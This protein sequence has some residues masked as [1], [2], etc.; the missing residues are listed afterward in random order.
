VAYDLPIT[1]TV[2][3]VIDAEITSFDIGTVEVPAITAP[4]GN[5]LISSPSN[6]TCGYSY[7]NAPAPTWATVSG[8]PGTTVIASGLAIDDQQY[9]NIALPAGFEFEFNGAN[10]N[11]IGINANGFIWFGQYA[12]P[13]GNVYNPISTTLPYEGVVSALGADL[14]A[15]ND[16]TNT[17]QIL[18][19]VTGT[20]PNRIVTV[21]WRAFKPWNNSGGFCTFFAFPD[22]NRYDFQIKLY[23]NG[24]ANSNVID[25]IHRDQNPVCIDGNGLSAQVGIRGLTNT[26]FRNRARTGNTDNTNTVAGGTNTAAI[27]HGG[28]NYFTSNTRMRYSPTITFPTVTPSPVAGNVCPALDVTLTAVST[29]PTLQ[30]FADNSAIPSATAL[31][32]AAASTG[33]YVIR[34]SSGACSRASTPP[35]DVTILPCFPI[36]LGGTIG[37]ETDWNTPTNWSSNAVPTL[38]DSAVVPLQPFLPIVGTT[39]DALAKFVTLETDATLEII[40]GRSLTF[41]ATGGIINNAGNTVDLGSGLVIFNGSGQVS[42]SNVLEFG[43]VT[44]NAITTLNTVPVINGALTMNSGSS[45]TASPDYSGTSTLVYNQSGVVNP[46]NE[47]TGNSNVAGTGIPQ[48]VSIQNSTTLELPLTDR[49]IAGNLSIIDGSL[50]MNA[51]SGDLYIGGDWIRNSTDGLFTHNDRKIVFNGNGP[52]TVSIVSP[53]GSESF[54]DLEIDNST[55]PVTLD[56]GVDLNVANELLFTNGRI[57]LNSNQLTLGTTG[58][59]GTLTG[60]GA[61]NYIIA[62]NSSS[63]VIRYVTTTGSYLFPLGD[64]GGYTPVTLTMNN[65]AALGANTQVEVSMTTSVHPNIGSS[66]NYIT[67][68]WT[69]EPVNLAG[70][71]GYDIQMVYK[72]ADVIGTEASLVPIKYGSSTG[73]MAPTGFSTFNNVAYSEIGVGSVNPATNTFTWTGLNSFSD[74]TGS[75]TG[76]SPLPISLIEFNAVPLLEAVELT[77]ITATEINNDY[78]T[79]ERSVD[80][81][82]F[83]SI[84]IEQGAGN[85]NALLN[86]RWVDANP[87]IGMNYYRLKQTDFDG[88]FTYSQ[89]RVVNFSSSVQPLT[90]WASFYPNPVL[91]GQVFLN[92]RDLETEQTTVR[93][94]NA[95][96]QEVKSELIYEKS[97]TILLLDLRELSSGVYFINITN[98]TKSVNERLVIAK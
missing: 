54:Y 23:E 34:A 41:A 5:K 85:S 60:S 89:V 46:A 49:G 88:S 20:T 25:I 15:H 83:E 33:T 47:W 13:S 11:S 97:G 29:A 73:W 42:G 92:L 74:F 58:N 38:A 18:F 86:Y 45:L 91:N 81:F 19:N 93:L 53:A 6:L 50:V 75:G 3:N 76:T 31:S 52:Q 71:P 44:V 57:D 51:V 84:H 36:W 96:G 14:E 62:D 28:S 90:Q 8:A 48:N 63:K 77:W 16:A 68:F 65:A 56:V 87:N 40:S 98:G 79:I 55:N 22:W 1:A 2:G 35:V 43:D 26:D 7:S 94:F 17:P 10:Y 32:Y 24:G 27:N 39:P 72:D 64:M 21:E 61:S 69:M 78:F 95:V 82:N 4:A 80:G 12:P 67:R 70:T 66:T 9:P 37:F 59:N 30:W